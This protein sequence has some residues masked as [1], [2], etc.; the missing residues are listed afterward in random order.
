MI[1]CNNHPTELTLVQLDQCILGDNA[2]E[3]LSVMRNLANDG[4][5]M[6]VVT[7]EMDFAYEVE[8][9]VIFMNEGTIIEDGTPQDI[10]ENPKDLRTREFLKNY[11]CKRNTNI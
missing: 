1:G 3:V 5:T 7:H 11:L 9:R 6:V 2:S 8:T 10:F 4:M